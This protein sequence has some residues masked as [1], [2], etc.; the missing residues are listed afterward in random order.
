V[1]TRLVRSRP[2]QICASR[3]CT[4]D[5]RDRRGAILLRSVEFPGEAIEEDGYD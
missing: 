2:P 1:T 3:P 4:A 5:V